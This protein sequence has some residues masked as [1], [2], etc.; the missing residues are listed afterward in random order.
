MGKNKKKTEPERKIGSRYVNLF[1]RH[2]ELFFFLGYLIFLS[3]RVFPGLRWDYDIGHHAALL[4][5]SI[6]IWA[7]QV[8]YRDFYPWYGPLFHYFLALFVGPAGNDLY[9]VKLFLQF[10]SPILCMAS[11]IVSLRMLKLPPISRCF[12]LTAAFAFRLDRVQNEIRALLPVL[13]I[14]LWWHGYRKDRRVAYFLIIPSAILVFFFSP[15][16]GIYFFPATLLF[17]VLGIGYPAA[18]R[19]R[20]ALGL[21]SLA[22][23]LVSGMILAGLFWG[24]SWLRNYLAAVSSLME[25]FRWSQGISFPDPHTI[26]QNPGDGFYYVPLPI[27][28]AAGALAARAW[29]RGKV[30]RESPLW[31]AV[32]LAFGVLLWYS[33]T[34]RTSPSHLQFALLP[35]VI[36]AG[37]AV[38]NPFR[39]F[40]P[41]MLVGPAALA[42]F[43]I[44]GAFFCRSRLLPGFKG[45][46]YAELMGVRIAPKEK[47]VFDHIR[48]FAAAHH[49]S[50][51]D[52]PL[53]SFYYA[54][55][56]MVP[57]TLF[58]GPGWPFLGD[59]DLYREEF[60]RRNPRYVVLYE[61]DVFWSLPGPTINP[62][63]DYISENYQSVLVARPTWIMEK[64][65]Q[66]R[67]F[68]T[69]LGISGIMPELGPA[70]GFL[71][72]FE[73][74]AALQGKYRYLEFQAEFIYS[75]PLVR[76][77]SMPIVNCKFDGRPWTFPR[78]E[79]GDQRINNTPGF[80]PFRLYLL[81][82]TQKLELKIDFPGALNFPPQKIILKEI[83]WYAL[84][85]GNFPHAHYYS[86]NTTTEAIPA[87]PS[88]A[89]PSD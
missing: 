77:F 55:L 18:T 6:R 70:N 38:S 49:Q 21:W 33:A 24:T 67:P 47:K 26:V 53:K 68:S 84:N 58:D 35:A 88:S 25:N 44:W 12:A 40:R 34:T 5:T 75:S 54:S 85:S 80:H 69:L 31:M 27:Y 30:N 41:V 11:L 22:G 43:L 51:I 61:K 65:Q 23:A 29:L 89:D 87:E 3:V 86:L 48:D 20:L 13:L 17:A 83:K 46:P 71:V 39:P 73:V 45:E 32:L 8:P 78:P 28:A 7:G 14:A 9:A 63:L 79:S 1:R 36:I 60:K 72:T 56:G 42:G 16:M 10:I 59:G 81:Y 4:M 37:L 2:W 76:K 62:L 74:P 15:E 82:P 57:A 64:R 66:P 52:F 50:Q 19:D